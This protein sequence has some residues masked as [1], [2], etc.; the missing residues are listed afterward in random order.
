M[1][2]PLCNGSKNKQKTMDN[3]TRQKSRR[4][5]GKKKCNFLWF[6]R[7]TILSGIEGLSEFEGLK[8]FLL[9]QD[10][11]HRYGLAIPVREASPSGSGELLP[12]GR[13]G[14]SNDYDI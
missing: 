9:W 13:Q 7:F 4:V 14:A 6:D 11:Q 8:G 5:A 3:V 10:F 12:A 2:R 1:K